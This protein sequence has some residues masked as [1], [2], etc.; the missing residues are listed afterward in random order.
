MR[1]GWS[2]NR[3]IEAV[4]SDLRVGLNSLLQ[5]KEGPSL[6]TGSY[7]ACLLSPEGKLTPA[8]QMHSFKTCAHSFGHL[9]G[10]ASIDVFSAP[11]CEGHSLAKLPHLEHMSPGVWTK[12][13]SAGTHNEVLSSLSKVSSWFILTSY[14][15]A[16][17]WDADAC[18][19]AVCWFCL[20]FNMTFSWC[21]HI[22][23]LIFVL[24]VSLVDMGVS[25]IVVGWH[26]GCPFMLMSS[27]I[28]S[29]VIYKY[30]LEVNI[31]S[32]IRRIYLVY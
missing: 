18:R 23:L 19:E 32:A 3:E 30:P 24:S 28:P 22:M 13:D 20:S 12:S 17:W 7:M 14:K 6:H 31:V 5:M 15:Q 29:T 26:W 11:L 8:H 27:I 9:N 4:L 16:K 10:L 1:F 2:S 21:F 25:W